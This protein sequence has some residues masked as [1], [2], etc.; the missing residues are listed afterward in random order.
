MGLGPAFV[1]SSLSATYRREGAGLLHPPR[2][3]R[4]AIHRNL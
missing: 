3:G 1:Q 2:C 4:R